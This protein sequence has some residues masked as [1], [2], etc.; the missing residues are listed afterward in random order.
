MKLHSNLKYLK[1][2]AFSYFLLFFLG[3]CTKDIYRRIAV[4]TGQVVDVS[5]TS[6]TAQGRIIDQGQDGVTD[7][8]HCWNI[9]RYPTNNN[10]KTIIF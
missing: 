7:Y 1:L 3:S 8:G 2:I 4:T 6:A 10:N 5:N 9:N